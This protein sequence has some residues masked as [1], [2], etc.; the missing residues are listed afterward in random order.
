MLDT[1]TIIIAKSDHLLLT[2]RSHS[3]E[4]DLTCDIVSYCLWAAYSSSPRE[5]LDVHLADVVEQIEIEVVDAA[6]AELFFKNI[7][8][9]AHVAQVI[10]GK[11][12]GKMIGNL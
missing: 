8:D 6:L 1:P 7:L 5:L 12:G 3:I 10:A 2:V 11:L 4:L 9:L